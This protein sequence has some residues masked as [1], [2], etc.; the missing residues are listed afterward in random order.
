MRLAENL[1]DFPILGGNHVE[2][3]PDYDAAIDR[4]IADIHAARRHA[5]LLYYLFADDKTGNRVADALIEAARAA[6]PA[7]C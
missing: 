3:L 2:L 6:S 4:L 5:Y 1:G 7:A